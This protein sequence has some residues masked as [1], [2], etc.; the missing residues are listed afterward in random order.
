MNV[1]AAASAESAVI[2]W[3]PPAARA[4]IK[5]YKV[6]D[7]NPKTKSISNGRDAGEIDGGAVF[8]G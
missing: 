4:N 6:Y 7:Y 1:A 5:G 2:R 3:D 8:G